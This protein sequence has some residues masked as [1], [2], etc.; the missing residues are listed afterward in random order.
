MNTGEILGRL[1]HAHGSDG[2]RYEVHVYV[3][4]AAHGTAHIERICRL[5]LA[6][7]RRLQV[8]GHGRYRVEAEPEL[9]LDSHDPG[10]P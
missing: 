10:A 6:D 3:Q 2:Q 9:V 7:G 1:F 4:P 5:C 8:L